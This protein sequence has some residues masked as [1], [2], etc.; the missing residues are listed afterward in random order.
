MKDL[1]IGQK[2][3][4]AQGIQDICAEMSRRLASDTANVCP[5]EYMTAVLRMFQARSCGKCVPCRVGLGTLADLL[6]NVLNHKAE[7]DVLNQI[8][9]TCNTIAASSD[10]AIGSE[11]A[12]MLQVML[13][14]FRE[15]FISHITYGRCTAQFTPIPCVNGCPAHVNIPGYIALIKNNRFADAVRLIRKDNPFPS[16]CA[17]ICEH[18]CEH[19]CRR[20]NVD[21][22]INIRGLKRFAIEHA[23]IV[24]S[25]K[26]LSPTG[27]RAAVVGAG[28]SGLTAAYF[29]A[30]MGHA[31]TVYE[32]Q[33]QA[34]GMLRYGI[35][36]YRLPD[37]YL[38]RDIDA[39]LSAG[40]TLKTGIEIGDSLPIRQL[41]K[42]YDCVYI[43]IGAHTDKKLGIPNEDCPG[44]ISAVNMLRRVGEGESFDFSGKQVV[45]IGGGN[46]AM[47]A[48]RTAR[49]LGASSVTCVY[50]RRLK[51]MTA[52]FEEIEGAA[53]ENCTIMQLMAPVRVETDEQGHAS[54]LWV[55]PQIIGEVAHGRPAPQ[56]AD[57]PEVLIPADLIIVA[58]GQ[59][60]VSSHFAN[61]GLPVKRA[62]FEA[63]AACRIPGE[64]GLFVGGDCQY[65]PAT[66][67]RAIE[68]GKVAAVQMDHYLGF[69]TQLELDV[70]I[71]PA[72]VWISEPSGRQNTTEVPAQIRQNNFDAIEEGMTPEAALKEC[73]R[74][75][76]CDHFGNGGFKNGRN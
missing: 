41:Q 71:P 73:S 44:V 66:A 11:A 26:P 67:I 59:D 74:C 47:D 55:Q 5:V 1:I 45:I 18:P 72:S 22:A 64:P 14:A 16:A 46:V 54:G 32:K 42:E 43:S 24:P 4:A 21:A 56:K 58:I 76:R 40:V 50:R 31:V 33:E 25:P 27:K 48:T 62:R 38:D 19:V 51:D 15:D 68:S 61:A 2:T 10:C 57:L 20:N 35:P 6:D 17:M 60:I 30:L 49:R 63:D 75:L 39:I 13:P 12:K 28:P 23:G 65:G 53:E 69:D 3:K 70:E 52:L 7:P 34:G 8:E 29:L 36:R 37:A 9:H